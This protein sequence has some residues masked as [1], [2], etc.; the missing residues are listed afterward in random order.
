MNG[1]DDGPV[2]SGM[3]RIG[4]VAGML[5]VLFVVGMGAVYPPGVVRSGIDDVELTGL[6]PRVGS[7]AD[8]ELDGKDGYGLRL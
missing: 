7:G 1:N 6:V 8:G 5:E 3:L 4:L 2:V